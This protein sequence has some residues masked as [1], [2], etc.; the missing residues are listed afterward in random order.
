[1]K[2]DRERISE[3]P[4]EQVRELAI[5]GDITVATQA[6]SEKLAEVIQNTLDE[7]S[8]QQKAM[9]EAAKDDPDLPENTTFKEIK[10]RLQFELPAKLNDL[11]KRQQRIYVY[12]QNDP[13]CI[14]IGTQFEADM[15]YPDTDERER[16]TFV[17]LGPVEA[18]YMQKD[19]EGTVISYLTPLG[20]GLWGKPYEHRATYLVDTPAGQVKCVIRR[21]SKD[22]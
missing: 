15:Y 4:F 22:E 7:I 19:Y 16:E 12:E 6:G 8:T 13:S 21:P 5:K 11:R 14:G 17:L 3:M 20:Q 10:T 9:G 1:M 18:M 2:I